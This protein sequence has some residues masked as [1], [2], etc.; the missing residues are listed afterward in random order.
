MAIAID[1]LLTRLRK[2]GVVLLRDFFPREPLM[3]L[4]EAATRCFEA[5]E[6]HK[7]VPEDYRFS[8]HARSVVLSA[9]LDFGVEGEKALLAPLSADGMGE[10]LSDLMGGPWRCALEHSWARKKFA[11][12]NAPGSGYHL[13]DWHQ[14]GA[15]G[16][17]FPLQPGPVIPM[18][19]L[20]TCWIPLSACGSDS[21]GLEFIRQPQPALLHFAELN[22]AVL[23]ARFGAELFWAPELEFGD[24]LVFLNSVLHRTHVNAGMRGDRLS[25]D[26]RIFPKTW[27]PKPAPIKIE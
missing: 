11:P 10:A 1:E 23:R 22:D 16:A 27:S 8:R 12:P 9:L 6:G 17:Q 3:R 13:Q 4:R 19:N 21:P 14:D 26:Y 24:G 25:L 20:A 7:P 18:S 5:I 2:E 15:L